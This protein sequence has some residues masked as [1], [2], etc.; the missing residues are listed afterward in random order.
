MKRVLFLLLACMAVFS[1]A[2]AQS[3]DCGQAPQLAVGGIG[4]VTPGSPNNVRAEPGRDA[5]RVG[6]ISGGQIFIVL[7]GPIC[8]EGFTWWQVTFSSG[9]EQVTGWTVE[10]SADEYFV[11][12]LE[13]EL[14]TYEGEDV[15]VSFVLPDIIA[16]RAD[17]AYYEE[18]LP[19]D[20][21]PWNHSPARIEIAFAGD[22]P[23]ADYRQ[24]YDAP[25][26]EIFTRDAFEGIDNMLGS[27]GNYAIEEMGIL[28][29]EHTD[30]T[31]FGIFEN[32]LPDY[33]AG[34]ANSLLAFLDYWDFLSGGGIRFM[35]Y[36]AQDFTGP[37]NMNLTYRYQG[38]T[39]D[40]T[41]FVS[42]RFSVDAPELPEAF[43]IS[44]A[45]NDGSDDFDTFTQYT[46]DNAVFFE[47]I[48]ADEYTPNLKLLDALIASLR[49]ES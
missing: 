1:R 22:Y 36:Y 21:E 25:I 44:A 29:S 10:S 34:A 37:T 24:P 32:R 5:D 20:A 16:S 3:G 47:A 35:S 6:Q 9:T 11:N 19:T 31:T 13:G 49:I 39:F 40:G 4:Q 2:Y 18:V 38:L 7:D 33:T 42:A 46:Q 41:Y 43:D 30:L 26:I 27:A 17:I 12:P 23:D 28:L 15:S 45:A 48:P 14:V 8:A